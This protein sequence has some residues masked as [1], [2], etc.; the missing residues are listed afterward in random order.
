MSLHLAAYTPDRAFA[1]TVNENDSGQPH[2]S[3]Q[4]SAGSAR[5]IPAWR[6]KVATVVPKSPFACC[7]N[8]WIV[9][10][11]GVSA[12][13]RNETFRPGATLSGSG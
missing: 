2:P 8:R 3:L 6:G 1:G 12:E 13:T 10:S 7:F 9:T 5:A 4:A 11:Y